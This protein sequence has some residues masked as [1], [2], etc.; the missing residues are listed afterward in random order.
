[1]PSFSEE[2]RDRVR[3]SLRDTGR[4]LFTRRGIR[5]TTISELTEPAGIGTGTFYQYFDSKEA[6]YIDILEQ[7]SKE[8]IPRLLRESFEAHDDPETA[9]IALLEQ[10]LNEIESNPIF[11]QVLIEEQELARIRE[12]VPDEEASEK[13]ESAIEHFLP[14]IESWYDEGRVTGSDP[15]T[16]AHTIR[17]VVRLAHEKDRIGEERYPAVRE[18][19]IEAV[20]AGLTREQDSVEVSNE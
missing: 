15:K 2:K 8:V 1:M 18:T 10:S 11:R 7:E 20:A 9:I 3:E 17:A 6:L 4:D 19:L 16:I 12:Q 5:A 13:R 14:Y